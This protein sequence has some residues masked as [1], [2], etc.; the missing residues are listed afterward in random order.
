M[1]PKGTWKIFYHIILSGDYM[2]NTKKNTRIKVTI[3]KELKERLES[4]A[5]Y[6][7]RTMSNMAATIIRKYFEEKD[8]EK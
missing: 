8:L 4:E 7:G 1:P 3:S 2:I 6:E 5:E